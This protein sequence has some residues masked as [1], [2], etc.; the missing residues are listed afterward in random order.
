MLELRIPPLLV[1]V[2]FACVMTGVAFATP[3]L[4]V[5]SAA[6][7]W[8]GAILIVVGAV[9]CLSGV[10][11]FR[12]ARTT[13]DP[14]A[15]D[16]A[17]ALVRGGIYRITRNPMYLG[18]LL[19]LA[20]LAFLLG[21]WLALVLAALFVPYMNRFQIEPEERALSRLFAAEFESFKRDVRR[22]L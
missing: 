14:T 4:S 15:P 16:K 13:V 5:R 3:S 6:L 1:T 20:G 11:A 22:W 2:V 9:V 7:S 10:M 17:T 12:A 8:I 19:A 21:S 18:F